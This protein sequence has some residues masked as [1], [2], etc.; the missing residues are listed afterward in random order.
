[1]GTPATPEMNERYRKGLCVDCGENPYRFGR[2]RCPAPVAGSSQRGKHRHSIRSEINE[3]S[4]RSA[5]TS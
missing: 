4:P 3:G 1:M 2:P 5:H